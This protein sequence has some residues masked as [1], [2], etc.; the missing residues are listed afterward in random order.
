MNVIQQLNK[1]YNK[2]MLCNLHIRDTLLFTLQIFAPS[3]KI[4]SSEA[5]AELPAESLSNT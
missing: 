4:V 1:Q 3:I 2:L 5:T